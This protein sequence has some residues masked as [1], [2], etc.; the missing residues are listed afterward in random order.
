MKYILLDPNLSVR[1]IKIWSPVL[2]ITAHFTAHVN[3]LTSLISRNNRKFFV[4]PQHNSDDDG[5]IQLVNNW[6]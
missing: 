3:A 5:S 2:R 6:I 4:A 1:Y